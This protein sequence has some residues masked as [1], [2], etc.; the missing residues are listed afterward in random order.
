[1][2]S[3]VFKRNLDSIGVSLNDIQLE[4]LDKYYELLVEWNSFMNLTGITDYEEVMLK[5]YLD[6][7][8]LKLPITGDNSR[9]R[10][11]DVGTGALSLIHI[12]RTSTKDCIS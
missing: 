8:V 4:Q 6:S 12:S 10:L 5:H 11:I 7:L 1:M 9:L 3:T 2:P